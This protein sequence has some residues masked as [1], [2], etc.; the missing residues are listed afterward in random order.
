[1]NQIL[2]QFSQ[3]SNKVF[4]QGFSLDFASI[5]TTGFKLK[6]VYERTAEFF[7]VQF[8]W[9]AFND[10]RVQVINNLNITN[11]QT[12]YTHSYQKNCYINVAFSN[13][14]SYYAL[15]FQQNSLI[16]LLLQVF[17]SKALKIWISDIIE[18]FQYFFNWPL[19]NKQ[20]TSWLKLSRRFPHWLDQIKL[21]QIFQG[22]NI[23]EL[24]MLDYQLK[25][26]I[27]L[28]LLF[29][30]LGSDSI[31]TSVQYYHCVNDIQFYLA[32]FNGLTQSKILNPKIQIDT[33]TSKLKKQ[34]THKIKFYQRMQLQP[35]LLNLQQLFSIGNVLI[36]KCQRQNYLV[37]NNGVL[38]QQSYVISKKFMQSDYQQSFWLL[39]INSNTQQ[40]LRIK[41][42]YLQPKLQSQIMIIIKSYSYQKKQHDQL[43]FILQVSSLFQLLI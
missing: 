10:E 6:M 11:P 3:Y 29:I 27:P 24:N 9:F 30:I 39:K 36:R 17:N 43:Q 8:Y 12:Q 22:L 15:E 7:Q 1:M 32:K 5:T 14:V 23:L 40:Q 38:R 25:K 21:F 34:T 41:F 16:I 4:P 26:H 33:L 28:K 20:L 2:Q 13:F 42:H 31:I 18:Q 35:N 37:Q 19:N